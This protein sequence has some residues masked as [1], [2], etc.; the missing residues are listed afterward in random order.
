[1]KIIA[2]A[3]IL[4]WGIAASSAD[5]PRSTVERDI[6]RAVLTDWLP[7]Q[8]ATVA[9]RSGRL[10][11]VIVDERSVREGLDFTLPNG[12]RVRRGP[13]PDKPPVGGLLIQ[14]VRLCPEG[15]KQYSI[16]FQMRQY[17]VMGSMEGMYRAIVSNGQWIAEFSGFN[18][19]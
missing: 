19:P 8:T 15:T 10:T 3:S 6:L 4:C 18:A 2:L 13:L 12:L 5:S 14:D 9:S 1:M 17:G 11:S 16:R 7:R